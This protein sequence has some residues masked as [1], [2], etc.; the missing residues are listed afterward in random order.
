MG[1]WFFLCIGGEIM[2]KLK[3]GLA[4]WMKTHKRPMLKNMKKKK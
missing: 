1:S 2:G 3:G 4:K